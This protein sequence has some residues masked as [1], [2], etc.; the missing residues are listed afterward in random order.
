MA[1]RNGKGGNTAGLKG[2]S[3]F[4]SKP[5]SAPA[6]HL[7]AIDDRASMQ[8]AREKQHLKTT[9][10]E[11]QESEEGTKL[12]HTPIS[13]FAASDVK[14]KQN[15]FNRLFGKDKEKMK[16]ESLAEQRKRE[17]I[18]EFGTKGGP[19]AGGRTKTYYDDEGN[20]I[21]FKSEKHRKQYEDNLA[22]IEERK[23]NVYGDSATVTESGEI[24]PTKKTPEMIR[25]THYKSGAGRQM[26]VQGE[27][28]EDDIR[29]GGYYDADEN[30]VSADEAFEQRSKRDIEIEKDRIRR[31]EE[32][33][34]RNL[35]DI[36]ETGV[37]PEMALTFEG[38]QTN[39]KDPSKYIDK[40][41]QLVTDYDTG[42]ITE[43]VKRRGLR[44]LL[45]GYKPTGREIVDEAYQAQLAEER[46]LEEEK[47][48]N[49]KKKNKGPKLTKEQKKAN[50]EEKKANKKAKQAA[51]DQARATGADH[52]YLN[53]V[54]YTLKGG[55]TKF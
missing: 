42:V 5:S 21:V 36:E 45:G 38:E 40:P 4:I 54:K 10:E 51:I 25:S 49:K 15:I 24:V 18:A 6:S 34:L 30:W 23:Q 53:G 11:Y 20:P 26:N 27:I 35:R 46:A 39:L 29:K 55:Q 14:K 13:E 37:T 50:K 52:Y 44:G 43:K 1:R 16:V 41:R 48:K 32:E 17:E 22:K 12:K 31:L 8:G 19:E 33:N 28:G 2:W 9:G 7:R 3:G 47:K